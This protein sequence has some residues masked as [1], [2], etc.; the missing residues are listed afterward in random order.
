M[1]LLGVKP[2]LAAKTYGS[3]FYAMAYPGLRLYAADLE[4]ANKLR[5]LLSPRGILRHVV[6]LVRG[7]NLS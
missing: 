3:V 1:F 7:L 4:Q 5:F 6:P 2:L